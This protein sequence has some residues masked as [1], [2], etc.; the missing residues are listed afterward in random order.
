MLLQADAVERGGPAEVFALDLHAFKARL[1]EE[2]LARFGVPGVTALVG[3]ARDLEK[4]DSIPK[5]GSVDAVLI[6]APCTGLGT[7]RRHP[8]KRWRV[9]PADI[10]SLGELGIALLKE[11][12][13]L[14]RRGGF[15]VYSTCTVARCENAAVVEAF[16]AGEQ[17]SE[18]RI[19]SLADEVPAEW[20][21]FVTDEG[22]FS[23]FPVS[24][25]PDGHFAA[26]LVRS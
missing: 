15:V 2:R 5:A 9:T 8:E 23:S 20:Q 22:Y 11:A 25:G 13:Q 16:L 10:E 19:D 7:L 24:D 6:D 26:R 17:G 21:A 12:A 14:V 3:D 1:L 4:V 18:W